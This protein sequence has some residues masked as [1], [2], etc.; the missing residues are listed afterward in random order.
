M[1]SCEK[2][3]PLRP[4][5]ICFRLLFYLSLV[6]AVVECILIV[7]I[8]D[9]VTGSQL[10][11]LSVLL[12]LLDPMLGRIRF[13]GL[14]D[15]STTVGL[16][17]ILFAWLLQIIGDKTC[18]V[19]ADELFR[20]EYSPYLWQILLFIQFTLMCIYTC[21]S[22]GAGKLLALIT[23]A[24]MLCGIASM[25]LMCGTFLFSTKDRRSVAFCLLRSRLRRRWDIAALT[26]WAQELNTCVDRGETG[27]IYSCF[28]AIQEEARRAKMQGYWDCAERCSEAMG[29]LWNAVGADRWHTFLPYVLKCID[30]E[31]QYYMLAAYLLQ[32]AI[33][34]QDGD[35]TDRYVT[36]LEC[37]GQGVESFHQVPANALETYIAF[38]SIHYT[39]TKKKAPDSVFFLL[40]KMKW[41]RQ[42]TSDREMRVQILRAMLESYTV[43]YTYDLDGFAES[44]W[45]PDLLSR[46]EQMLNQSCPKVSV[47][48]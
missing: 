39:V 41:D 40:G 43:S 25:W 14:K 12:S 38:Y 8:V 3:C 26:A 27:H 18:G 13:T 17:G 4:R 15:I 16:T 35:N 19:V 46:F 29:V 48:V 11:L 33:L 45:T 42:V 30:E 28:Q 9:S 2:T 47:I 23:F 6:L 36:V 10:G 5:R 20:W 24:G 1:C 34:R 37:L 31:T 22:N 7:C 21:G 32:A 44:H